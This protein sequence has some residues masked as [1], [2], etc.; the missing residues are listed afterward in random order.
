MKS[1]KKTKAQRTIQKH[2][3]RKSS[4]THTLAPSD[5]HEGNDIDDILGLATH[6]AYNRQKKVLQKASSG[7]DDEAYSKML[8]DKAQADMLLSHQWEVSIRRAHDKANSA[9]SILSNML[10][11]DA[12]E[13]CAAYSAINGIIGDIRRLAKMDEHAAEFVYKVAQKLSGDVVKMFKEGCDLPDWVIDT[14]KGEY[15]MPWLLINGKPAP[16]APKV[17]LLLRQGGR[18]HF[19]A[20]QTRLVAEAIREA[21]DFLCSS[22][23]ET[24]AFHSCIFT[25]RIREIIML[26]EAGPLTAENEKQWWPVIRAMIRSNPQ[27]A[28]DKKKDIRRRLA[29]KGARE[30]DIVKVREKAVITEY[31]NNECRKAFNSLCPV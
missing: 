27:L 16:N 18:S 25:L 13:P 19:D 5:A 3:R 10:S 1:K 17:K 24:C 29:G 7:L 12:F 21:T 31:I 26:R 30:A 2:P 8:A 14:V 4:K 11:E 22:T 15:E 20:P 6:A 23:V 9:A 28:E